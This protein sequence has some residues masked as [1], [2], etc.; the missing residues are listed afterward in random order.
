MKRLIIILG[1]IASTVHAGEVISGSIT[2]DYRDYECTL[3]I[4]GK[5]FNRGVRL[6]NVEAILKLSV[7]DEI[8]VGILTETKD[9]YAGSNVNNVGEKTELKLTVANGEYQSYEF[10]KID[11]LGTPYKTYSCS[12]Q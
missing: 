10:T 12:L 2:Q 6:R 11:N 4:L 9:G 5:E 3:E 7:K 8:F 1:L